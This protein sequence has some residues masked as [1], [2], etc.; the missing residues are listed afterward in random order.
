M[1]ER[2][3]TNTDPAIRRPLERALEGRQISVEEALPLTQAN[4]RDL[5]TLCLV[6]DALRAEQAGDTVTY[7]VNRNINFTN[8]CVKACRFCAFSR[9]LRSEQGYL[10]DVD[11]V[12]RRAL[13]ARDF[14][15]TE[16]CLQA[17]L[18]PRSHGRMYAEMCRAIKAAAP[19]LHLHAF[20]PEEVRY[21]AQLRR[22]SVRD[23]LLELKEAGLG[24]LPGTSAE[25][26]DDEVRARIAPG[27]ITTSQWIDVV[28]TA[29]ALDIPTTSTLM[30]GHVETPL[31]RLRH[32]DLLR[33]IQAETGGFTEF[34][35]LSFVHAEAPLFAEAPDVSAGPSE[36]E[37]LRLYAIARLLLGPSFRNIQASW[38]KEGLDGAQ[39]LLSCGVNDLG[40]TLMNESISTSAGAQHGQRVSPTTLRRMVRDAGRLP[41]ERSTGY[42]VLR[43]FEDAVGD[44]PEPLDGIPDGDAVFGSYSALIEEPRFRY[45]LR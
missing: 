2:Q 10:L 42:E 30:F 16:V 5:D 43:T 27:R 18:I 19:D 29:H 13:Q 23:F 17:G 40:G 7:V 35:P 22:L 32:L 41:A 15:A 21:G 34:V 44:P 6:A 14:G 36:A 24:S 45:E 31:H 1:I 33:S 26:L 9:D 12:V 38:V 8:V 11:E 39:R 25:I 37:V 4:G 3:L 28:T 20:S